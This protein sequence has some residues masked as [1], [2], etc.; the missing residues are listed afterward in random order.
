MVLPV[1]WDLKPF[2]HALAYTYVSIE[3]W[4]P[5]R[6]QVPWDIVHPSQCFALIPSFANSTVIDISLQVLYHCSSHM[7]IWNADLK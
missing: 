2:N 3:L 5:N 4:Q 7:L 6:V 1:A